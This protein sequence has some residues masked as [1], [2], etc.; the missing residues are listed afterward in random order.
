MAFNKKQENI[1][2]CVI[3]HTSEITVALIKFKDNSEGIEIARWVP[4]RLVDSNT[5]DN[6][7]VKSSKSLRIGLHHIPSL[8]A[9]LKKLVPDPKKVPV[10]ESN[11][12]GDIVW[13]K[14]G[15]HEKFT[16]LWSKG[17]SD[18]GKR[19]L[20]NATPSGSESGTE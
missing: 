2:Y 11:W 1:N 9:A 20:R 12:F 7:A 3:H 17:R 4:K 8:C 6:T 10:P 18:G 16:K 15:K 5:A 13:P 14:D 19:K